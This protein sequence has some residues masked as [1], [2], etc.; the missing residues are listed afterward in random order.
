ME[1]AEAQHSTAQQKLELCAVMRKG[2]LEATYLLTF[3][4]RVASRAAGRQ[5]SLATGSAAGGAHYG[6]QEST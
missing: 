4:R 3:H 5:P 2:A 1:W 6:V